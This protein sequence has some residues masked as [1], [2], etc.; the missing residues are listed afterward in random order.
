MCVIKRWL[1]GICYRPRPDKVQGAP[2]IAIEVEEVGADLTPC[3][4]A[5]KGFHL[6]MW[7]REQGWSPGLP[8]HHSGFKAPTR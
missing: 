1:G 8:P 3:L 7:Q 6:F 2:E 5:W 4:D